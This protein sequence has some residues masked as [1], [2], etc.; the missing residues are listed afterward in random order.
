MKKPC[1]PLADLVTESLRPLDRSTL[2]P[3]QQALFDALPV[4]YQS[5]LENHNG[6]EID[7]F[8]L[9]FDTG[10]PFRTET[11]DNPSRNDGVRDFFGF[12]T[13]ETTG[14][15]DLLE[16]RVRHDG[17]QFLPRGFVAIAVCV[18]SSLVCLSLRPNDFGH[19]YYW[20]WYWRY[21]WCKWFFDARTRAVAERYPDAKATLRDASSPRYREVCDA[22]NY[23]TVVELAASFHDWI[24]ECYDA[25]EDD[26]E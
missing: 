12:R 19:V 9:T 13:N 11:V 22:F 4:S 5:F 2:A 26:E 25:R 24:V 3:A 20:D 1:R 14:P 16:R 17:E 7:E 6:G 23:A 10:V 18:Q 8:A 21:P 15:E